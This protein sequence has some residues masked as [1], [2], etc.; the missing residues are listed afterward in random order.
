VIAMPSSTP[1]LRNMDSPSPETRDWAALPQDILFAVFLK[2][3]PCDIM[4]GAEL[5][6]T[7][8]RRVAV[9]Y[10]ALWRRVD[11]GTAP[12]RSAV[13]ERVE[14]A[15]AC[16]ALARGAGRCEA[17]S[18]R[19]DDDL[20]LRLSERYLSLLHHQLLQI[21]TE[22]YFFFSGIHRA[23]EYFFVFPNKKL[24]LFDPISLLK[25]LTVRF[26]NWMYI[27]VHE[28]DG[29]SLTV[30]T[31]LRSLKLFDCSLS[32]RELVYILDTCPL[33]ESL[34]ITGG[35]CTFNNK[36]VAELREKCDRIKNLSLPDAFLEGQRDSDDEW[37]IDDEFEAL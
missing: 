1:C 33:L 5:V 31:E 26:S 15:A 13:V 4:Q 25:T 21:G 19:V 12:S 37:D 28:A 14:R 10:P 22:L 17:F 6:C 29:E 27:F 32:D 36:M 20:L 35:S 9:D 8:W 23:S 16:A 3:G 7:T 11:M 34:H 30:A 18:G 24:D 2:L